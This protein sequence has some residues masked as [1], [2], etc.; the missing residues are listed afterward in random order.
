MS[1]CREA[2]CQQRIP[3]FNGT[4]KALSPAISEWT[5]YLR[6]PDFFVNGRSQDVRQNQGSDG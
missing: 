1:H 4:T 6:T 5:R 2:T 3:F